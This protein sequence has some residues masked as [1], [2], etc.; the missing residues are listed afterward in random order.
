[1]LAGAASVDARQV[2]AEAMRC[3]RAI[4]A[5]SRSTGVPLSLL[6]ALAPVESGLLM[7][8]HA[9]YPWPWTLNVKGGGSYHFLSREAAARYLAGLLAAGIDDID[10]GC[11]QVNWHWHRH[12]FASPAAALSPELNVR[13]AALLL[14]QYRAWTGT[15]AGAVGLYHSRDSRIADAYRCRVARQL[16]NGEGL[17]GCPDRLIR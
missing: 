5:A 1:Q 10:I 17:R 8:G 16:V 4:V 11:M 13:Y 3:E 14:R 2:S 12:A 6:R 9:R 15:W 7:Q